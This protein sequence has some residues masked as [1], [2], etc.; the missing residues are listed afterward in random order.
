MLEELEEQLS[1]ARDAQAAAKAAWDGLLAYFGEN[2]NSTPSGENPARAASVAV[3]VAV[4]GLLLLLPSA[5][6]LALG[7]LMLLFLPCLLSSGVGLCAGMIRPCAPSQ[8][9]FAYTCMTLDKAIRDALDVPLRPCV[10]SCAATASLCLPVCLCM[11]PCVC[12]VC[13]CTV[14]PL[15]LARAAAPAVRRQVLMCTQQPATLV[16]AAPHHHPHHFITLL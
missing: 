2:A 1:K 14:A 5:C 12:G 15:F 3:G 4:S 10:W 7:F 6:L 16:L 9:I 13:G 11:C 8:H